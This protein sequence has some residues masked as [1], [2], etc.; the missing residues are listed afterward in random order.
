MLVIPE[1]NGNFFLT[2]T[3]HTHTTHTHNTHTHTTHTHTTHMHTTHIPQPH[4]YTSYLTVQGLKF[5]ADFLSVSIAP[6][7]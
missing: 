1:R 2:T 4:M 3:V 7:G 6:L 5:L